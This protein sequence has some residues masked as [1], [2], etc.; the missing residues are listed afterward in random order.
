MMDDGHYRLTKALTAG[1]T[2]LRLL[3]E[4]Y[5]RKVLLRSGRYCQVRE[6]DY[7]L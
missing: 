7:E 2:G 3:G 5:G 4:Y 6:S 1:A